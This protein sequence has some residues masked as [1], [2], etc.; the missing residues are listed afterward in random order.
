[1]RKCPVPDH[2]LLRVGGIGLPSPFHFTPCGFFEDPEKGEGGGGC[3][4]RKRKQ[5]LTSE[6]TKRK[7]Q[8]F[9]NGY[10]CDLGD[11]GRQVEQVWGARNVTWKR[12]GDSSNKF[13]ELGM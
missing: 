3:G 5:Q 6:T 10:K 2:W 4:E 12:W 1:M 8:S 9:G 11:K 13:R 7:I